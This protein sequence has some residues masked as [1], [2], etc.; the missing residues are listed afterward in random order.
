M[1]DEFREEDLEN[2]VGGV[3]QEFGEE[4]AK[5]ISDA[6]GGEKSPVDELFEADLNEVVDQQDKETHFYR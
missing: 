1:N 3:P 6:T 5:K 4:M 2:V